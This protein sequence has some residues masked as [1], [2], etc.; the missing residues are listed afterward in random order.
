MKVQLNPIGGS[1]VPG[2]PTMHLSTNGGPFVTSVLTEIG[3]HS[4]LFTKGTHEF[5]ATQFTNN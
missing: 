4:T 3:D 1:I 2:T 5:D